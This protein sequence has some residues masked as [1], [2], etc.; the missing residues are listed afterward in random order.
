M[1][2]THNNN[3]KFGKKFNARKWLQWYDFAV[4]MALTDVREC[5]YI[6]SKN[7]GKKGKANYHF[8]YSVIYY[9]QLTVP[10]EVSEITEGSVIVRYTE[11]EGRDSLLVET[12]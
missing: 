12:D 6:D 10:P 8:P 1:R 7:I 5:Y 11:R 4:A 3:F 2:T 9:F